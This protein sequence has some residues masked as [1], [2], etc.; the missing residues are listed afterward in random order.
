[1][2]ALSIAGFRFGVELESTIHNLHIGKYVRTSQGW[3]HHGEHCGSEIV[4]PPLVGHAGLLELRRQINALSKIDTNILGNKERN[5][6]FLNCGFHVHVD[7]QDFTL[8][9]AKRLLLIASRFDPVIYSLMDPCRRANKY[10]NHCDYSE[11]RIESITNVH[12]LQ[13]IQKNQRYSGVNFYAFV[14]HGTVEFRYARGTFHWPTIYSLV[15][16]YLRMVALA[17]SFNEIPKPLGGRTKDKLSRNKDI[18]LDALDIK[19]ESGIRETLDQMFNK[20]STAKVSNPVEK[21]EFV[22]SLKGN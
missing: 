17:K 19:K 18:F 10:C 2:G 16:M 12:E 11:E 3:T 20:N 13:S 6:S 8:G 22:G 7:V 1:M 4:S 14:K 21:I 15:N 9:D 5:L